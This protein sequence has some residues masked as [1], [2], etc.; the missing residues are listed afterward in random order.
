MR[1]EE[2]KRLEYGQ[3]VYHVALKNPDGT[4]QCWRVNGRVQ[5]WKKTPHRVFVP[6][7]RGLYQYGFICEKNLDEFELK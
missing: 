4:P 5:I 1:L 3:M 6:L 2:A 7:K